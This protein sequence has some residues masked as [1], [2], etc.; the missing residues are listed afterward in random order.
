MGKI[1]Y[2]TTDP[3]A[4]TEEKDHNP[5][6]QIIPNN[7]QC[8]LMSSPFAK[9]THFID[10]SALDNDQKLE[11]IFDTLHETQKNTYNL[12]TALL[13]VLIIILFKI[14]TKK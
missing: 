3:F 10:F 5:R 4:G 1:P 2:T 6:R 13:V 14:I 11:L 9:D 12:L 7:Q 8:N